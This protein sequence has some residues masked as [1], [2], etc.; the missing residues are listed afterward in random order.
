MAAITALLNLPAITPAPGI[1]QAQKNVRAMGVSK[2]CCLLALIGYLEKLAAPLAVINW[3]NVFDL[4]I[5]AASVRAL[6]DPNSNLSTGDKQWLVHEHQYQG[7]LELLIEFTKPTRKGAAPTFSMQQRLRQR[8]FKWLDGA[9]NLPHWKELKTARWASYEKVFKDRSAFAWQ[10][11]AVQ[12]YLAAT[13]QSYIDLVSKVIQIEV[14]PKNASDGD[15]VTKGVEHTFPS[16]AIC[17]GG[18]LHQALLTGFSHIQE[19]SSTMRNGGAI[20]FATA[21]I[22][23]VIDVLKKE[24]RA[25]LVNLGQYQ[26]GSDCFHRALSKSVNSDCKQRGM[27]PVQASKWTKAEMRASSLFYHFEDVEHLTPGQLKQLGDACHRLNLDRTVAKK[28]KHVNRTEVAYRSLVSGCKYE[29]AVLLAE[30]EL[31]F[32]LLFTKSLITHLQ[33]VG[34]EDSMTSGKVRIAL[35]QKQSEAQAAQTKVT[36]TP[37]TQL[38]LPGE[39]QVGAVKTQE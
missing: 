38:E 3:K 15:A 16:F 8:F 13:G 28:D 31:P 26:S 21:N 23:S 7:F 27:D 32:E 37:G 30:A 18:W 25:R 1:A 6:H 33:G 10:R 39:A 19:D 36:N 17:D 4:D 34:I 11:Q 20:T 29:L 2:N 14:L 12:R 22:A 9:I 35:G 5:L 24:M